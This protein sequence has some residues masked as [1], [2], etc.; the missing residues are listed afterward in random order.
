MQPSLDHETEVWA[1]GRRPPLPMH[2]V[3][4]GVGGR[5]CARASKITELALVH[6]S[7]NTWIH[8]RCCERPAGGRPNATLV[9]SLIRSLALADASSFL[10]SVDSSDAF[11]L[12][13]RFPHQILTIFVFLLPRSPC[14]HQA[15]ISW[16]RLW[17]ALISSIYI[18][19]YIRR[20]SK[21]EGD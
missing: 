11:R 5:I 13:H 10:S 2:V 6:T 19:I 16:A 21:F 3:L 17:R 20:Y 4:S 9:K 15:S 18:Y 12:Q 7:G 8:E 1:G 14:N